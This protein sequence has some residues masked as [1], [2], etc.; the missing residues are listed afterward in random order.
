[1]ALC[2]A[3]DEIDDP[4][5]ADVRPRPAAVLQH[6]GVV[7]ARILQRVGEDRQP[8]EGAVSVG[9]LGERDDGGGKPG[10]IDR[11]RAEGGAEDVADKGSLLSPLA[12]PA[13]APC[14]GVM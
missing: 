9:A 2:L 11:Y 8:V 12:V 5:A 6:I 3:E 14:H 7:A 4:A 10:G 13:S 1:P